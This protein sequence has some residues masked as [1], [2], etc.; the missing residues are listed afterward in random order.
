MVDLFILQKNEINRMLDQKNSTDLSRSS[1]QKSSNFS[2]SK[3]SE[4][5]LDNNQ[6]KKGFKLNIY[7][8]N[9]IK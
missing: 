8:L 4:Q 3:Y 9:L 2:F 6:N 5:E 7:N 1:M